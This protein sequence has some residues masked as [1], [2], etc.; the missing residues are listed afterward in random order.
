LEKPSF[1]AYAVKHKAEE[2]SMPNYL[3]YSSGTWKERDNCEQLPPLAAFT[4]DKK[5]PCV[6]GKRDYSV[7]NR[8]I[9][10]DTSP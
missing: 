3:R 9:T 8:E 10:S 4:L 7:Y 1:L 2:R 6:H 5:A